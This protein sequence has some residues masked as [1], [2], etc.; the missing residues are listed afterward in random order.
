M[1][2]EDNGMMSGGMMNGSM[3]GFGLIALILLILII[4]VLIWMFRSFSKR[5]SQT[6]SN[7]AYERL[8]QRLAN[9]EMSEKEYDRLKQKIREN[10]EA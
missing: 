9:G 10:N 2:N 6:K 7:T 1:M 3:F 8:D 5:S 4:L